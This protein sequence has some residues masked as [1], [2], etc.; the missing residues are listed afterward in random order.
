MIE[1]LQKDEALLEDIERSSRKNPDTLNLWWLGQSGFLAASGGKRVLF[2]PYLSDSLTRK[3]AETDK[4][5]ERM[6]ERVVAPGAL[7]GIDLVT[8]T[9]HHTDHL[10]GETLIPLFEANPGMKLILPEAN[11]DFAAERLGRSGESFVGFREGESKEVA[12]CQVTAIPAA[13]EDR[14]PQFLGYVIQV[15][16][17]SIYHSGDT[18]MFEG[19]VEALRPHRIDVALLPIN[20]RKPERR[21]AG[22]LDG[23]E[24][25]ELAKAVGARLAVPCHFEMFRFNTETPDLFVKSCEEVGQAYRVMRAGER[26]EVG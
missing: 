15:G 22:N 18:L 17:W 8:S 12:G 21:V 9:H 7:K 6:T 4:P 2:D 14:T 26:L 19:L 11:R 16:R 10:D 3:Y 24:A 20:G 5:H 25:A 1:A 13:H 23:R